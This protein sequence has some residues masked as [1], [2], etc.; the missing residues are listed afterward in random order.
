MP[1]VKDDLVTFL[2][3]NVDPSVVSVSFTNA[4]D[5]VFAD[6]DDQ[7]S[8]PQVA[9]VSR[10]PVVPGGGQTGVTGI[11][12]GGGG[13][14]QDVVEL[15]QVDCWGGPRDESPYEGTSNDPDTVANELGEEVH[16]TCFDATPSEAPAGYEWI[17]AD[18]PF[19]GDDTEENP[20]HHREIVQ[21]R[22]KWTKTP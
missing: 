1:D 20:T 15:V 22:M 11:D 8:Y 2:R 5:I 21:V 12:P 13:S 7:R 10:D 4:D 16:S 14:I 9:V 17:S 18:P 6:Y 3:N 19:E